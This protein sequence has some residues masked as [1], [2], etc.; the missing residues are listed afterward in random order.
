MSQ[1]PNLPQRPTAGLPSQTSLAEPRPRAVTLR[2][3]LLGLLGVI[4]IC[5]LSPYNDWAV[6]NTLIVG[7]FMP[8]GL[9]LVMLV[10]VLVLNAAMHRWTPG[11]ALRES[12]LAIVMAMM[13]A[14]CSIPSSGL[15]RY[16]PGT[17]I[18]LY[19]AASTSP[20]YAKTLTEAGLPAWLMPDIG[21]DITD[22]AAIGESDVFKD[23][24]MRS[25]DGTV[26]WAA[27]VRPLVMWGAFVA[28]L[29]GLMI[30]LTIIVRRQWAE[31][32]RLAFPLATVYSSLVESPEPGKC[33]NALFRSSGFWIAAGAVF[34]LHGFN[35]FHEYFPKVP[36]IP[37][38]YDFNTTFADPPLSYTSGDFR[39]SEVMFS[40]VGMAFF[41]QSKT[42]FSLWFMFVLMQGVL[43]ILGG[44]QYTLTDQMR[45][46]Q[47]FGGAVV[48]TAVIIYVGRAHW[49]MVI[50]HMFG[51]RRPDETESRYLPYAFAGWGAFAC[52]AGVTVFIK[53]M[54]ATWIGSVGISLALVMVLMLVARVVAE[55]GLIF[56]QINWLMNRLWYYPLFIPETPIR[57]TQG[58]FFVSSYITLLF[59]DLRE[60]FAAFFITG[61]RVADIAA[62]EKSRRWRTGV[63]Y[64]LAI[65][66][67]LFVAYWVSAASMLWTE[68]NYATSMSDPPLAPINTYGTEWSPRTKLLDTA[69][70]YR[71]ARPEGHSH[72]FHIGLG[73]TIVGVLSVLRLNLAWWPLHPIAF[74]LLSSWAIHKIWFSIMLGWLAKVIM[75]RFGGATLLKAGRP[76]FIGL[77]VGEAAA[78]AFWMLYSLT[79][80]WMGF[81]YHRIV[82][83][84]Y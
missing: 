17:I 15:M 14:A 65:V 55:T 58:T 78:A 33:W 82:L 50:R 83:L 53:L 45:Q 30:F 3:V 11:N 68:Y 24:R 35:G 28:L 59:H 80:N 41:L 6:A 25:S 12:E 31:N 19:T 34:I 52:W 84:P 61:T 32:E 67:A 4:F 44:A 22:P 57:S 70:V 75:V 77:V 56:V 8:I 71:S 76:V 64:V 5:G 16:L 42:S 51:A 10:L 46:D 23:Y 29:W 81:E 72:A 79:A 21:S 37:R 27:W 1:Q 26:P 20:D 66:L 40:I 36:E 39:S 54:G 69:D 43:I 38:I 62:Y 73:A 49:W 18:G 60:S 63:S 2:S 7:N 48:M 9:V 47:T 13:L 74:V